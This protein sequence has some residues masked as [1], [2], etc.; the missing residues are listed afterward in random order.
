[1]TLVTAADLEL[2]STGFHEDPGQSMS[3]RK[4]AYIDAKWAAADLE[5]IFA[6]TCQWVCHVEQLAKPGSYVSVTIAGMPILL[7]R[8]RGGQLRAFYNVCKH[9]AHQLLSGSGKAQSSG[10]R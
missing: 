8:D 7:V 6:R 10:S 5:A 3:L 9:R 2:I 4:E 1:M